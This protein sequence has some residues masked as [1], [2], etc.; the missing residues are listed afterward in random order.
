LFKNKTILGIIPARGG[1]KRLPN[2]NI[3][4]FA[5]KPLIAWTIEAARGS[6]YLDRFILSSD[7]NCI[8]N[9]ARKFHCEV[10]F[11]RPSR[12]AK[13]G[14]TSE[15]VVAHAI[16]NAGGTYDYIVLLQPTSPL[17]NSYHI[18]QCIE[19]CVSEG[20]DSLVTVYKADKSLF[21]GAWTCDRSGRC[22]RSIPGSDKVDE[23]I[24]YFI[25]NGAVVIAKTKWFLKHR[26]LVS[27]CSS[28]YEMNSHESTDIDDIYDFKFA[29]L[30]VTSKIRSKRTKKN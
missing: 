20:A 29:E 6:C 8:I 24:P 7:D 15:D 23:N 16:E 13:D 25:E 17:R 28:F 30:L 9:T 22:L 21:W 4:P 18:D 5:G 11:K 19:K 12:L 27:S 26:L 14:S 3:L 10:P 1:S 2:K